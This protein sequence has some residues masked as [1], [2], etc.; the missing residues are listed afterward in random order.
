M[1]GEHTR[2]ILSERLGLSDEDIQALAQGA[3]D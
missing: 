2:Q 1:L 3:A